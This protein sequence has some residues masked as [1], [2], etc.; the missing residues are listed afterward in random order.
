M[1]AR[2]YL[3]VLLLAMAAGQALTFSSFAKALESYGVVR[4]ARLRPI[5]GAIIGAEASAGGALLL[6]AS[7]AHWPAAVLGL[8]VAVGWTVLAVVALRRGREVTNCGCFG[9]FLP[10]RLRA[11]VLVQDAFF[12]GVAGWVIAT[13][14]LP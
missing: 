1:T 9:N 7:W 13:C 3:A 14:P 12:V 6:G 5:A 8:A 10:Q 4:R 2:L 11:G